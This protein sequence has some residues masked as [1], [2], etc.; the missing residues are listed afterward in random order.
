MSTAISKA[1][2]ARLSGGESL[3]GEAAASQSA[4]AGLLAADPD[5]G[6]PA[7]YLGNKNTAQSRD[8][9]GNPHP[10][11]PCITFRPSGGSVDR[12][13]IQD[14]GV[15]ETALYD[16]EIWESSPSGTRITDIAEC[17]ERLLDSRRGVVSGL[18]LESGKVFA[19]QA[20]S[21]LAILYD[22]E[23]HAWAGLIRYEFLELRS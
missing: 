10:I 7:V 22:A 18:N 6:L 1:L 9:N 4:L 3:T 14:T 11:V 8:S 16:F 23:I 19:F 17:V 12:R 2:F 20:F 15:V 21:P 13:F 5:T